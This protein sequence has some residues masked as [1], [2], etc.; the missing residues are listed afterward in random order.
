VGGTVW[1]DEYDEE[2][3]LGPYAEFV[4]P[5]TGL[6]DR[7]EAAF[8][9]GDAMLA[10][11]AYRKLFEV[12]A[13]EDDYG[14]GVRA[15]HLPDVAVDEARARYLRAVFD[16][17]AP[18]HRPQALFEEMQLTRSWLPGSPPMLDDVMQISPQPLPDSEQF[19]QD[20]IAFLRTQPGS[21]A[22][23]WLREAVRLSPGHAG[24]SSVGAGR[25]YATPARLCGLVRSL[26]A[27]RKTPGSAGRSTRS[28]A[29]AP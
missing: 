12:L 5:V 7:A 10:R 1:E 4:E 16:T 2:D 20:W 15:E 19:F 18:T 13:V 11:A 25:G 22:D 17:E 23:A 21:D 6:F 27:R 29:N 28:L 26:G 9:Y 24:V 8:E 14:C 3:S